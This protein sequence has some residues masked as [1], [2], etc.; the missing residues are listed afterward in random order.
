MG[1]IRFSGVGRRVSVLLVGAVVLGMLPIVTAPV[2][3]SATSTPKRSATGAGT[4][5]HVTAPASTEITSARS[6]YSS[7]FALANGKRQTEFS[8]TPLNY[9]DSMGIWQKVD[10]TLVTSSSGGWHSAA[11][12]VSVALPA[13]LSS[14]VTLTKG[15]SLIGFSLV[16]GT[17]TGSVSG[18]VASYSSVLPATSATYKV[19]GSGVKE[20][21]SLSSASA[22]SSF[23][24]SLTPAF[25]RM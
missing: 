21:L 2:S 14:P 20:S 4:Q 23:A 9:Q 25:R 15:G 10:N 7:T 13:R 6:A 12:G 3:A 22:P 8:T 5:T 17:G 16:G 11:N 24:W 1:S 18:S 19:T